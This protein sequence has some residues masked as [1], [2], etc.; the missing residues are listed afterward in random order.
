[1]NNETPKALNFSMP[2]EWHPH[3][4]TQLH[5][6]ANR[7]TWPGERL[8]RV[9][10]VY[11][12]IIEILHRFE[13]V[14]LFISSP[15]LKERVAK[16]FEQ[17]NIGPEGIVLHQQPVNDVWARDCGPIFVKRD[18]GDRTEP[19]FAITDWEYNAWG[20]KYPPYDDDNRIPRYVAETFDYRRFEP[21]M[22]LEGGSID[23]NGDGVLLTT[24]SVLMNPNRNPG[25]SRNQIERTLKEYLGIGR[26]VWLKEGLAGDDTDGHVDDIARFLNE[27]TILAMTVEDRDDVNYE[28]LQAN[29]KVLQAATNRHGDSFRIETLPLPQTRIADTTVDGSEFVPASYANFYLANGVVLVPVYDDPNDE[30]ALELFRRYYPERSVFGIPSADLVWG[31]GSLHC[32]TQPWYH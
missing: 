19:E 18:T 31:Q 1:M 25:K 32:I 15:E 26:I 3:A 7:E 24:E 13:P 16:L 6:P 12:D 9:E 14:H 8:D 10:E 11:L 22:V 17:R 23:A 2:P 21:G 5:W 28:A 29:L 4:A 20:G 30:R 27:D